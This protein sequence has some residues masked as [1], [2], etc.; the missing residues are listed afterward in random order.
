MLIEISWTLNWYGHDDEKWLEFQVADCS[1]PRWKAAY[2][3]ERRYTFE[4]GFHFNI[5]SDKKLIFSLFR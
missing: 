5:L 3:A 4:M 1:S 2:G